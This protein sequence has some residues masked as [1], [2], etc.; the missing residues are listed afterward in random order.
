MKKIKNLLL[1]III[2]LIFPIITNAASGTIKVTGAN[3][4]VV[5]NQIKLSVTVSSNTKIGGWDMNLNYDKSFLSLVDTNSTFG[6][7][8]MVDVSTS[9]VTSKTYTFTFKA[10]KSGNTTISVGS[11]EIR[12]LDESLINI[13]ASNKKIKIMTKDELE[14]TY[15]KDN[16]L[17]ELSVQGYELSPLFDKDT[18]EYKVIVPSDV[19]KINIIASK[20]D[21]KASLTGDGEKE[22]VEGT[23]SFEIVVTAENGSSKKYVVNVEV[24]DINPISATIDGKTYTIVKRKS[25]LECPKTY[26]ET[27]IKINDVEVPAFYSDITKF[28]LIGLKDESGKIYLA[29]YNESTNKYTIYNEA[30]SNSL[31]LY[32]IDFQEELKGYIKS[33]I[34]INEINV[35]VYK[36]KENSDFV[37]V[38][39][40]NIET[41]KYD[42]YSYDTINKTFQIWNQEE[43]NELNSDLTTYL[44]VCIAFGVGLV[45]AFI[46]IV[47]LLSKRGKKNK[48]TKVD[49][50]KVKNLETSIQEKNDVK[51][52]ENIEDIKK[53]ETLENVIEEKEDANNKL[54]KF[55]NFDFWEDNRKKKK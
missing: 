49:N 53:E 28:N 43:I 44:Y 2:F 15:S 13:T 51:E 21:A 50:K 33:T 38:Y 12:A 1:G 17:K 31:S 40:M 11:Y 54:E 27:T 39:A 18:L 26:E 10:L 23:N 35:P 37:I 42:Y 52:Q 5:G 32:I 16:N 30:K 14:A 48:K 29:I 34:D 25:V 9:G 20:N 3:T 22:V 8:S 41:G 7:T 6:G 47:C 19:T 46:L 45:F 55:D 24:E 4:A 36:F